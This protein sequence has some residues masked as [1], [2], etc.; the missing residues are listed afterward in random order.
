MN[1]LEGRIGEMVAY[2]ALH[3]EFVEL[4]YND[5]IEHNYSFINHY[6]IRCLGDY[7]LLSTHFTNS[8]F[9]TYIFLTQGLKTR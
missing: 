6:F 2:V 7:P 1:A 4:L 3:I 9:N 5:Q 8:R